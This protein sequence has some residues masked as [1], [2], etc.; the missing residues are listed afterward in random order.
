[1]TFCAC[2]TRATDSWTDWIWFVASAI[3]SFAGT[4]F[5]I[6]AKAH[7]QNDVFWSLLLLL[8]QALFDVHTTT[9]SISN[10][11][12]FACATWD[13]NASAHRILIITSTITAFALTE[14]FIITIASW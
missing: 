2:T 10:V 11:I 3:A 14:F 1:M 9:V 6:H 12:F 4:I 13:A 5:F 7:R 8:D